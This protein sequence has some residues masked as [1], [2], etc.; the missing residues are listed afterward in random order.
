MTRLS[1]EEIEAI[2]LEFRCYSVED[3][4]LDRLCDQAKASRSP[5]KIR[6]AF[7]R[8]LHDLIG[9]CVIAGSVA[10]RIE[11]RIAFCLTPWRKMTSLPLL[12]APTWR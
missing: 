9:L 5:E 11:I 6:D 12:S 7:F 3:D 10:V 4:D 8:A 1:D 2:Q